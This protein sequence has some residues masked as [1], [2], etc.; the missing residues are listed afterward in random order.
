[1]CYGRT[2]VHRDTGKGERDS[3]VMGGQK[4]TE[5]QGRENVIHTLWE[6][7]SSQRHGEGRT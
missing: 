1:M 5:T 6:D 2:E 3:Y 7:R 4:F